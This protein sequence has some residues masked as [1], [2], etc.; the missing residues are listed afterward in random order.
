MCKHTGRWRSCIAC[1][2]AEVNAA[3]KFADDE[4]VDTFENFRPQRRRSGQFRVDP[5]GPEIGV[6][7]QYRAQLEKSLF[8]PDWIRVR[9]L[10]SANRAEKHR[11]A[12]SQALRSL[13]A[14][15]AGGIDGRTA[16]QLFLVLQ[17]VTIFLATASSTSLALVVTS[18]PMPS[19][20]NRVIT[21][22]MRVS[23]KRSMCQLFA[24]ESQ[25]VDAL[26]ETVPRETI[27]AERHVPAVR[28]VMRVR[29][30]RW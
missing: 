14:G 5:D 10:G 1:F 4:Q 29:Q 2:L 6:D 9:P 28:K 21:A 15:F 16:D 7:A 30:R 23:S 13:R 12:A 17:R 11:I 24:Q 26:D 25:L 8:R 18:G 3:G 22:S 19:P 20:G 27:D